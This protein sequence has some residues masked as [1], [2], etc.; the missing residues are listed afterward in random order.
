MYWLVYYCVDKLFGYVKMEIP[1][2]KVGI[3]KFSTRTTYGLRAMIKLANNW[4]KKAVSLSVIARQ[5]K[6]SF[7]YLERIFARLRQAGLVESEKGTSGGYRL[8]RDP[9][10][11]KIYDIVKVLEGHLTLFYCLDENGKV[12]CSSDKPCNVGLVLAKV[13]LAIIKTLQGIV[14]RDLI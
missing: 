8:S 7:K 2:K 3:M 12:H 9:T 14:L 6:I 4:P 5:E 11:I 1:T 10:Q 13:Q